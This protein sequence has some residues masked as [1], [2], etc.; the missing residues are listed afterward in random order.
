[1]AGK[2]KVEKSF[3]VLWDDSGGTPRD[4]TGD[5][6]PGSASG[7]GFKFDQV[8]MTGVSEG[9][10]NYLA[11]HAMSEMGAAFHMNDT[12]DTGASTVLNATQGTTGTLTFQWGQDG[13]APTTGD[14][15]WSGEY[16]LK[17]NEVAPDSG[18]WVHQVAWVPTG[19]STPAWGTV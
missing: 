13:A 19:T 15:E 8:D 4:L 1:M 2:N 5:L 6:V 9:F 18:K 14:L 11:G 7:G 10:Y 3:R 12:A 17:D 16:L